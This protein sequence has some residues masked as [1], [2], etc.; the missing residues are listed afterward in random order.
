MSNAKAI[1][2]VIY[3]LGAF[4]ILIGCNSVDRASSESQAQI[5]KR[6]MDAENLPG[7]IQGS[8]HMEDGTPLD[9]VTV[10]LYTIQD[11]KDE[12]LESVS[13]REDA[14]KT[15]TVSD[16]TVTDS[17]GQYIFEKVQSGEHLILCSTADSQSGVEIV[18]VLV[19]PNQTATVDFKGVKKKAQQYQNGRFMET[20][21]IVL[22]AQESLALQ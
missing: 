18:Q 21:E 7:S 14:V 19:L 13:F 4:L 6:T 3:L 16:E 8:I 5:S 22:I 2:S 17:N 15:P 11:M 9:N 12:G 20:E 10:Q 1:Q